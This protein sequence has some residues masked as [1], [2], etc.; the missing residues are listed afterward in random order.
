M[1]AK[2]F[3]KTLGAS[4]VS[5]AGLLAAGAAQAAAPNVTNI[6]VPFA[7][8]GS[9]DMVGRLIGNKLSEELGSN[10]IVENRSGAGASIG[11][12]A[13]VEAEPD[14]K[15]LLVTPNGPISISPHL[16]QRNYDPGTD[17]V[18][19]AL[20]ALV[21]TA[22]AVNG[23]SDIRTL[24]DLVKASKGKS[25]SLMYSVP[26]MGTHMHLAG[27]LFNAMTGSNLEAVAYR[28]TA[29]ASLAVAAG[30]V[31]AGISDLSS[32]LPLQQSDRLRILAVTGAERT[33]TAPDIPTVAE[34][35][36]KDYAAD[37]WIGMFAPAGTPA[38][39]VA[40]LN[41]AVRKIVAMPDVVKVLN[42][43]GLEAATVANPTELKAAL[44]ADYEQWGK[45][46]RDADIKV[47]N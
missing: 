2:S 36:V 47:E 1:K 44:Q 30:E 46:I 18:P 35:G 26:A 45:V 7:P 17:L 24:D 29:P 6:I 40:T 42:G 20:I 12:R 43:A 19:V 28:G 32:L 22:I 13:V 25:Q 41:A 4:L 34:L 39:T 10:V 23:Q 5:L 31:P 16:Y 27:E 8:G 38:D 9:S 15:T 37:A 11:I 21:P 3:A 33:S 14:G